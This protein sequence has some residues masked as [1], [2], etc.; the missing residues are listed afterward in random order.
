MF[1]IFSVNSLEEYLGPIRNFRK[2]FR[3]RLQII[4]RECLEVEL[5]KIETNFEKIFIQILA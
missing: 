1:E 3:E 5:R 2:K 4:S